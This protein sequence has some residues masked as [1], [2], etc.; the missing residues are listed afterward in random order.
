[1]SSFWR[2]ALR[3]QYRILGWLDP[4]IRAFWR[5]FGIGITVELRVKQR[6]G[7]RIRSR[8]VGLLHASD[9]RYIGHPNGH[10]G[11]TRDLQEAGKGVLAWPDGAEW[12]FLATLLPASREREAAIRATWQQP[13]PGNLV[14]RLAR[15]HILAVGVYFR[16]DPADPAG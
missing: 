16:L 4:P 8:L 12:P 14:Y 5:Q 2:V 11:W 7:E 9:S 13:F 10:V 6:R 3:L 15:R 1:M